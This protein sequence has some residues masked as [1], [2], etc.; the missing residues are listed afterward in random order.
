[1]DPRAER[2]LDDRDRGLVEELGAL[3]LERWVRLDMDRDIQA[4][5]RP[6]ARPDLPLVRQADLVA[7]VDARRDRDAQRPA[8]LRPPVAAARVAGQLDDPALAPAAWTG[9]DVDHLPEHRLADRPHLAATAALRARD[10]LGP[11]RGAAAAAGL[12]PLEHAELDLLLGPADGLLEGDPQVVAQ[13]RAGWRTPA[14]RRRGAGP[15]PEEGVE[16][17]REPA[18]AFEPTA[19]AAETGNAEHVVPAAAIGVRQHLV[20]LVDLGEPVVGCRVGVDVRV[21]LLGEL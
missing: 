10:R 21:P 14:S 7:L 5:G 18:E 12:A 17:V 1:R 8:P 3:A 16:D 13:I 20:G 11:R 15:A 4:A 6:A 19:R 9:G 2:G